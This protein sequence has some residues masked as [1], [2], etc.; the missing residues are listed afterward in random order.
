MKSKQKG[1]YKEK[2]TNKLEK[3]KRIIG[4]HKYFSSV[5]VIAL[6]IFFYY[7]TQKI[8]YWHSITKWDW[9]SVADWVSP[10]LTGIITVSIVIFQ[11]RK[12]EGITRALNIENS[13]P[14]FSLSFVPDC[15][16]LEIALYNPDLETQ[17]AD[18]DNIIRDKLLSFKLPIIKNISREVIYEISFSFNYDVPGNSLKNITEVVNYPNGV[19]GENIGIILKGYIENFQ[20]GF[21]EKYFIKYNSLVIKFLSS[22]KELVFVVYKNKN[23][24]EGD[25]TLSLANY[26]YVIDSRN[27][28]VKAVENSE[29][30]IKRTS[31]KFKKLNDPFA[32][33]L[34]GA[35]YNGCDSIR[36]IRNKAKQKP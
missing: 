9:G 6:S 20:H 35:N 7:K 10:M 4:K 34:N 33:Y 1:S 5:L 11:V 2:I 27:K 22:K 36:K 21:N 25:K 24:K 8:L 26:Y 30:M 32:N 14:R 23:D 15:S 29:K 31:D 19:E 12:Q 3:T 18:I 17:K 13:R 28:S 16:G